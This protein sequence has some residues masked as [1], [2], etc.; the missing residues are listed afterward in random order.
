[1]AYH[2]WCVDHFVINTSLNFEM[3]FKLQIKDSMSLVQTANANFSSWET[4]LLHECSKF[5]N[6]PLLETKLR[7]RLRAH[8]KSFVTWGKERETTPRMSSLGGFILDEPGLGKTLQLL[9]LVARHPTNIGPT[10]IVAP[11]HLMA[12]WQMEAELHFQDGVFKI[13]K[14]FG[15]KRFGMYIDNDTDIV[16]TSYGMLKSDYCHNLNSAVRKRIPGAQLPLEFPG[17]RRDSIF[18]KTWYRM[19]IDESHNIR[20]TN[21]LSMAAMMLRSHICW[22]IT[23]T[24]IMNRIDDLYNQIALLGISPFDVSS[25]WKSRISNPMRY[26]P[27][28]TFDILMRH[29]ITPFSIRRLKKDVSDIPNRN[30][31]VVWLDFTPQENELYETLLQVTRER[32]NRLLENMRIMENQRNLHRMGRFLTR[33]RMGVVVFLLRLRQCCCHPSIITRKIVR[34]A[35]LYDE[36]NEMSTEEARI[37]K[38]DLETAL[39]ILKEKLE[40]GLDEECQICFD[41]KATHGNGNCSHRICE[42]CGTHMLRH[43]IRECPL[44][45]TYAPNWFDGA[46][47][48]LRLEE[49]LKRRRDPNEELVNLDIPPLDIHLSVKSNWVYNDLQKHNDKVVIVSQW[50]EH[51]EVYKQVCRDLNIQW[52]MLSG[53]TSASRRFQT[54]K[55]FQND[56]SIRVCLLSMTSSA[57]GI[58]LTS[59]C[60][61]YHVDP[62]WNDSKT[63][64]ASDRVHRMGQTK[65]VHI[66]HL[67]I[68][69]TIE[70]AMHDMQKKKKDICDVVYGTKEATEH[71]TYANQVQLMLGDRE[72]LAYTGER[73]ESVQNQEETTETESETESIE[74][75]DL[76]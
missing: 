6:E 20:N 58:N 41:A 5:Y 28:T 3:I 2:Y 40:S 66:T 44:C 42:D 12:H 10:L 46:D 16:I 17:F 76:T 47:A 37:S 67:R 64:Q 39:R 74:I 72:R 30:E 11:T 18:N 31:Q 60:R 55:N 9:C 69:N 61:L 25:E 21:Q 70:D 43:S 34:D 27:V 73:N 13:Q 36:N 33:M 14:Y 29:I 32:V 68:K 15:S 51:L 35:M 8:Q 57:E 48:V 4:H 23:A 75:E 54:V 22:C 65:D 63:T 59:A 24:P 19:I 49:T 53:K 52:C 7:S 26:R 71:M 62:W 38:H 50:V 56:P 45:R 1:M